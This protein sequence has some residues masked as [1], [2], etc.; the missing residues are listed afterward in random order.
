M[1]TPFPKCQNCNEKSCAV[2]KLSQEEL[3]LLSG[4]VVE[5]DFKKGEYLFREQTLN[6]HVVYL[7]KGLVKIHKKIN[8]QKDFILKIVTPPS[9]LGLS[10]VFGDKINQF[11]ATAIV[12]AKVCFIDINVF[13]ELIHRNGKFAFELISSISREELSEFQRYVNLTQKQTPG[14]LAGALL[15]FAEKVYK[16]TEFK[17]PVTRRELAELIGTTR[18]NA[19]RNLSQ[20]RED[21]LIEI[22]KS[23][24]ILRKPEVLDHIH[25]VG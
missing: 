21:G 12:P 7:R 8:D 18:E 22:E 6:S 1:T 14:R 19:T 10:T 15:F 16:D 20:F 3:L 11:S 2:A 5:V 23:R 9:Y 17:L 13:K 24:I 4:G 25:N